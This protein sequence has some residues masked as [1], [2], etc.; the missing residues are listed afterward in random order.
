MEC[1]VDARML[2]HLTKKDLRVHLK[3]VD[4][5]HRT[6]LQYG[7]MCLKRLNYDRKELE[8]RREETQH[9]IKD[10]LVWTNDQVI[11]WIQSIG[12][13]EYANNLVESGVHG[14]LL[15][16]DENFDHNSLALVLQIPTQNTQAR[17]VLERE[18]NNLLA[19]GTDRRLDDLDERSEDISQGREVLLS[20]LLG[21]QP[22]LPPQGDDKTFRRTPSWRKRFRPRDVH[23]IN[24][25]SGSA[26]TL[27]AGF[28]VTS[29]VPLP[30]PSA[31]AKKMPPEVGASGS[32]RLETST[33][34]TYSC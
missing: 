33:V 5:F 13:R 1:L 15:A 3:M 30:P 20:L 25:L 7:I 14:A 32:P 8:R 6:S 23:S 2:D 17:Q 29:L 11:H 27:P 18:F 34:R 21:S 31:P 10:V 24:M 4:S 26:E 19:L 9:E 12:L 28:R 16:L 22:A